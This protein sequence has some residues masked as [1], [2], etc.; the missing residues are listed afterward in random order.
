[1]KATFTSVPVSRRSGPARK[2]TD[3]LACHPPVPSGSRR[4]PYALYSTVPPAHPV[5]PDGG[6]FRNDPVGRLLVVRREWKRRLRKR[7]RGQGQRR[8]VVERWLDRQRR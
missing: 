4:L 1:M 7:L 5:C 6:L 3:R 2:R 8:V